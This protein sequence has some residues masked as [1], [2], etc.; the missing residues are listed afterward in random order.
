ML[1]GGGCYFY[2]AAHNR[3]RPP[4]VRITPAAMEA[5]SP[6]SFVVSVIR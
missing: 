2:S 3:I 1:S 4:G 6:F 5:W